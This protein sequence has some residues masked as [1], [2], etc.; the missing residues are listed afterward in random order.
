MAAAV[1][2]G[3]ERDRAELVVAPLA[4]RAGVRFSEIAPVLAARIQRRLPAG[5]LSESIA[6]GQESKR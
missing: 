1:V 3:V 5:K 2:R 4:M 6:R